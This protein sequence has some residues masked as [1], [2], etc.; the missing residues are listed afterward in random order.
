MLSGYRVVDATDAT[1]YQRPEAL[2]RVRVNVPAYVDL[3]RVANARVA[4]ALLPKRVVDL[5]FVGVNRGR[6]ENARCEM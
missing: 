4:I 5:V 2:N 6:G 3:L 1:L